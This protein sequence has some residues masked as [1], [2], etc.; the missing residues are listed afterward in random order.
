MTT[1]D[2]VESLLLDREYL[3]LVSLDAQ[4]AEAVAAFEETSPV[5]PE[6]GQQP[7]VGLETAS[8]VLVAVLWADAQGEFTTAVLPAYEGRGLDVM[9]TNDYQRMTA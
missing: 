7:V 9:L 8:K 3:A 4:S 6:E 5:K 1:A 2:L